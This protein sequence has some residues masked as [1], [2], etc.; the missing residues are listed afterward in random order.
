MPNI[1][2]QQP[3]RRMGPSPNQTQTSR[4]GSVLDRIG[5]ISF[6]KEDGI[7]ILL[8]GQSGSGKTSLWATFPGP[9]LVMICSGGMRPGELRSVDVPEYRNKIQQVVLHESLEAGQ[10]I[11]HVDDSKKYKTLV[12]DH[13]SGLQDLVL[14]EILGIDELPAQKGFGIA[15]QQQWGQVTAQSKEILRAMLNLSCN[16]VI[17]GQERTFGGKDEG[18]D[19][20]M[21]KPVV[22]ADVLPSLI[23]WLNPSCDYV[24]QTFKRPKMKRVSATVAGKTMTSLQRDKG[25][26][27]CLRVEPHDV[28]CTKF[29][30][31]RGYN[32]PDV[33]VDPTYDKIMQTIRGE[34]K[35]E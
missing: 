20:D 13:V 15:S 9:I 14:K 21:I 25:V 7:S 3:T 19:P 23:R 22:G 5:G 24:A 17:I 18:M 30:V 27:Y 6:D 8:Y 4:H 29:R 11:R 33:I 28:F 12:L 35:E 34:Y 32:I 26:E 10:V 1:N 2:K 16:V 31:P